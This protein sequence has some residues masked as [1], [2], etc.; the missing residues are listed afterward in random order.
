[1]QLSRLT[2]PQAGEN[3]KDSRKRQ[4]APTLPNGKA[5][6]RVVSGVDVRQSLKKVL[7]VEERVKV[8]FL[9]RLHALYPLS[10]TIW[11]FG[12]ATALEIYRNK[13]LVEQA[14]GNLKERLNLRRTLVSS[15]QSLDGK[16]FVEFV[17][18]IYLSYLK[19]ADAGCRFV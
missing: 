11:V 8:V 3:S 10:R 19:K 16:L 14:F 15:E 2:L 4:I 1:M 9:D 12:V 5:G 18:L 13:D 17:A 6:A 7:Q